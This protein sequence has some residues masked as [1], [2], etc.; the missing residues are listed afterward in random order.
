[1][2]D[3]TEYFRQYRTKN[4]DKINAYHRAYNR[5]NKLK[6]AK[7]LSGYYARVAKDMEAKEMEGNKGGEQS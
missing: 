6:I 7:R 3:R 4:K 2:A 5:K 1:M